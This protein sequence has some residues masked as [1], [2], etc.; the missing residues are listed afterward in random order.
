MTAPRVAAIP[1]SP[2]PRLT[3][4]LDGLAPGK[5]PIAM[6]LGEPQHPFPQVVTE[7]LTREAAGFGKYP[8]VQGTDALR[9]AI[10]AWIARRYGV[11]LDPAKAILPLCGTREGLFLAVFAITP[12]TK[13]GQRPAVLIPNPFY[14]CYAA[15]AI[16]AGAEPVYVNATAATG[17]LPDWEALPPDLLARTAAVFMCSPTNPEGAVA[18]E[19][20]WRTLFGLADA[21]DFAVLADE[22]YAEIYG[23]T[24]PPGA[25]PARLAMTG[26]RASRLLVFHSLSKRSSLPGLRSGFVAGDP[27]LIAAFREL[28][29]TSAPTLPLPIQAASAAVWGDEEHVIANRALYRSKFDIADRVLGNVPGYRRPEAGF[30]L[31]LPVPDAEAAAR[32]LW[33]D[34]GVRA[35]PGPY[36]AQTTPEGNPGSGYLRLALVNDLETTDEALNRIAQCL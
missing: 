33:A 28:R 19:P 31:W 9:G 15:A 32:R 24:P 7:V 6:H 11:T 23:A 10:A 36:L 16:A 13:R 4:L 27:A 18:R 21:Y 3:A 30:F 1:R 5:P 25:L 29:S 17:F 26:G 22:C 2:F 12:D 34:A 35:L 8:P 20:D 14:Q